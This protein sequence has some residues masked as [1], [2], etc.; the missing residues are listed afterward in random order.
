MTSEIL[1]LDALTLDE[2]INSVRRGK[3]LMSNSEK[4]IIFLRYILTNRFE[5]A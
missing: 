1:S 3:G 4:L 2:E 5:E